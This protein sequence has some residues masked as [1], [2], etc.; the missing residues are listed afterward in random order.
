M[1]LKNQTQLNKVNSEQSIGDEN[2]NVQGVGS[3]KQS[4]VDFS[5]ETSMQK[6]QGWI[7]I[8]RSL[9]DKGYYKHS[10][11]VHLW[12]HL[13]MLAN[14]AQAEFMWNGKMIKIKSG[15]FITGR[16]NLSQDTGIPQTTIE[17]I[18]D[19]FVND[20][21]IGQQKTTK[22]RLITILNWEK[23]QKV[24]NKRTTDGQQTDTNKNNKNNKNT[25][26]ELQG[27][28]D[29]IKLFEAVNPMYEDI[30]KNTTD[31]KALEDLI[32]KLGREKVV[33]MIK[34]LPDIINKPYAPKVTRP[35]ELKRDL[36]K[37]VAFYNQEKG[38]TSSKGRGFI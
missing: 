14:H 31:R 30:Y 27:L 36:G 22:Y 2:L 10:A 24:D 25:S 5:V 37:L 21:Q 3:P 29:I 1:S 6:N 7:K 32:N 20:H 12:V 33:G 28:N 34:H 8:H 13:L 26:N 18:L 9:I 11:Y 35:Y 17:R 4:P 38:K 23:F 19:V 16:L 15:Q